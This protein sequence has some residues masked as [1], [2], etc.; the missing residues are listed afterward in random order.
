MARLK[1]LTFAFFCSV[2]LGITGLVD[3]QQSNSASAVIA[4][5]GVVN[6]RDLPPSAWQPSGAK[7]QG[8]HFPEPALLASEKAA[9]SRNG[10]RPKPSP[11]PSSS[12]SASPSA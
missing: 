4:S 3:A 10:S 2:L 7:V 9:L 8:R 5:S 12:P 6:V 1:N 11:S